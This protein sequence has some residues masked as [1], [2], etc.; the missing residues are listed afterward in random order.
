[1]RGTLHGPSQFGDISRFIPAGAGNTSRGG[2]ISPGCAVYPRWRGEH[3][4]LLSRHDF[5]AGLS[6][7]A[8]GTLRPDYWLPVPAR[9]IPAGAGNTSRLIS[10]W[11]PAPVYPRWRGEHKKIKCELVQSC[12]LSPLARGTPFKLH[13]HRFGGRFIPAG[14]GNTTRWRCVSGAMSVYPRW[15]GE[16]LPVVETETE[17]NGLSPLARGT[18]QHV[19]VALRTLRFIPAGAGNTYRGFPHLLASPVYPR[20]RGEHT[21]ANVKDVVSGGLSPLARRTPVVF[22]P[23]PAR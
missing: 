10:V 12:G 22:L 23:A 17:T 14:A 11:I 15:R 4:K 21:V 5:S 2:C 13:V 18:P 16:H 19:N 20:W 1:M 6:P 7:L 3:H 8:R 9:F